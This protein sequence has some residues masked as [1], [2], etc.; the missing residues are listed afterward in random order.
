MGN[1]PFCIIL[2]IALTIGT[3]CLFHTAGWS[4]TA[5]DLLK[6]GTDA[7]SKGN[8]DQAIQYYEQAIKLDPSVAG[9]AYF[10][11]GIGYAQRKKLQ[12]AITYLEKA[13]EH[14]PN[15]SLILMNLANAYMSVGQFEKATS[16]YIKMTQL[17]PTA[18]WPH[19]NLANIY[20]QREMFPQAIESYKRVIELD[21]T[22]FRSIYMQLGYAYQKVQA[23]GDAVGAYGQALEK[24]PKSFAAAYNMG[25]C[26]FRLNNMDLA[27][28]AYRK[29][30][31]LQ[32]KNPEAI[33]N[34]G[35]AF[36]GKGQFKEAED[37]F[38]QALAIKPKL[39]QALFGMALVYRDHYQDYAKAQDYAQQAMD[40]GMR[41]SPS[42]IDKLKAKAEKKP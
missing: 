25:I 35:L 29:A 37:S 28:D 3:T 36:H 11:L 13:V 1:R 31:V 40:T 33:T 5:S 38:T 19:F 8:F 15:E 24:D 20:M 23:Y 4:A 41:V 39:G 17:E 14:S 12:S 30:L 6:Q 34:L 27:I 32:P 9:Q 16:T 26:Y 18:A 22:K 7:V 21:P 2:I 42:F 10:R